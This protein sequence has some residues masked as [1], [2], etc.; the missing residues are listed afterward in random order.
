MAGR[1]QLLKG[2]PALLFGLSPLAGR[3]GGEL[4]LAAKDCSS[5]ADSRPLPRGLHASWTDDPRTSR[6]LSWFTDGSQDPG[7]LLEYGPVTAGMDACSIQ[8]A[9]FPKRVSGSTGQVYGVNALFHKATASGLDP[10]LPIRYRVGSDGFGWSS[11]RVLPAAP[12]VD[13]FR[14]CHFG[15][16]A[17]NE[18]SRAVI[19]G[20]QARA[21]DFLMIAGDLSYA[22]G[23]QPLWDDYFN[24]LDPLA[25]GLPV[26]T[27]PG[28]HEAKDGGGQGYLSR[29][30]M[31]GNNRYYSY[32]YGPAHFCV[33]T[34]GSLVRDDNPQAIPQWLE[35]LAWIQ[36]DLAQA[37]QKR[38]DGVIDFIIFVQHYS[39]WTNC[40]S[41]APGN[42]S[43]IALEE[44]LLHL[45]G[46]DLLVVG[47][48]HIYERSR[49]MA[50]GLPVSRGGYV[51]VTQGGGGQSLYEL[52]PKLA[53]WSAMSTVCHGFT[54][55]SVAGG[56][57]RGTTWS[58]QGAEGNLLP[59]GQLRQIDSFEVV[60][61]D[62][63]SK[64]SIA[65]LARLP[66]DFLHAF[67]YD[68]MVQH[69]ITRNRLHDLLE[70]GGG[71]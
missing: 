45:Y 55:Y 25:S 43:A 36:R 7:T 63:F 19:A 14:F 18:N 40:E 1:R 51:Q 48:D 9:P 57:I 13:S 70:A 61:R 62:A 35:E 39:L 56:K 8:N 38:A 71:H 4:A 23:Q 64:S 30:A 37:A 59:D 49:P 17:I 16:H 21:P 3:W 54:E 41:R 29:V 46:V 28:N 5:T 50:Y 53:A 12:A 67:N 60:T 34:G 6:T 24:M 15:D 2:V 47:H 44:Y 26:M 33:S 20:V 32:Q 31:P 27:C 69:T 52:V 10:S 66:S 68:E 22:N 11:V 65:T 58:V 42:F